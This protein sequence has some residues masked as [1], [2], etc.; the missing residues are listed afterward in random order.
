[1]TALLIAIVSMWAALGLLSIV[2]L[3]SVFKVSKR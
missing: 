3:F 1:M 2:I